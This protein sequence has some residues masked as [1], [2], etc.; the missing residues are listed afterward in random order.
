MQ[1][2]ILFIEREMNM[3][4]I[5]ALTNQ[6]GGV[7]KTTTCSALC[8]CLS[9]MNKRVL[10]IDLD[11]QGNLSFSLGA[12]SENSYT[13]YDVFKGRADI[14]DTVQHCSCCDV[15]PANILLS[16]VELELTSVGREYILRE[17]LATISGDYDYVVIDTPPALSILTINAY[18]AANQLIIPMIPEILSLQGIAQL[19]ETIFAVKKYY[20]SSLEIRG[21]LLN[22]YS[23][24][25]VLTKEVEELA[26][27]IAEQ[28]DTDVFEQKISGSVIIAEAPAHAKTIVEYAPRSKAAR[29]YTDLTYEILGLE[30]PKHVEQK[31]GRGRPPKHRQKLPN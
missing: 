18:A 6:K 14:Y 13:I 19:K 24:R 25:L 30:K 5:I 27:I 23:P 20:N 9:K 15:I 3:A 8:G 1:P 11:P 4:K 16:G 12:D 17:H 31:L 21:I 22:K 10:A 28:L 29:E 26:N 2:H 7:G